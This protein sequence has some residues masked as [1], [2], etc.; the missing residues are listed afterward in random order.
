MESVLEVCFRR[1]LLPFSQTAAKEK[2][3]KCALLISSGTS[4]GCSQLAKIMSLV[5][6]E[7]K[8]LVSGDDFVL[9]DLSYF[10]ERGERA[11][12][13]GGNLNAIIVK[14]SLETDRITVREIVMFGRSDRN[15]VG[16]RS[17]LSEGTPAILAHH[18]KGREKE[19]RAVDFFEDLVLLRARMR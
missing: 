15:R 14:I 4:S 16:I 7:V 17:L 1:T 13:F 19:M 3:P 10:F 9:M 18:S 2:K 8:V 11:G 6:Q 5:R 12:N